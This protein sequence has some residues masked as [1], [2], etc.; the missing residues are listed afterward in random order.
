[1]SVLY[2]FLNTFLLVAAGLL[3]GIASGNTQLA[4]NENGSYSTDKLQLTEAE[5][6]WLSSHSEIR[7]G[8]MNSWPPMDFVDNEGKPEGIGAHFIAALNKRLQNKLKIFPG[9]WEE[10]YADVQEHRL[11]AIMGITP[12]ADREAYF[13]FT[14]PYATIPHA[15]FARKGAGSL[16]KLSDLV[17]KRVGLERN[18]FIVKLLQK[19]YPGIEIALYDST[20]DVLDALSKGEVDAY[21]GNRAV[22][23]YIIDTELISNIKQYGKITETSSVNAI[24]VRKD[25]P[26]LRDILQK[27]LDSMSQQEVREILRDSVKLE[28]PDYKLVLNEQEKKWLQEHPVIRTASD[29]DWAPIE[30]FDKS[31]KP[32]GISSDYFK[33]LEQLLG[34]KFER[35]KNKNWQQLVKAFKKSEVDIFSSINSTPERARY[36]DFTDSYT[37]FPIAIFGG[38]MTPYI[39]DLKSLDKLKGMKVGVVKNYVYEEIVKD[40]Y[41]DIPLVSANNVK[42]ALEMLSRGETDVYIGNILVTGYYIGQLGYSR[43]KVVGKTPFE[44]AQSIGVRKDWPVFRSILNKALKSI[45][46]ADK[47]AIYNR[48]ISV[49]YEYEFDYALLWKVLLIVFVIFIAFAF[50]NHKLKLLNNQLVV[51]RNEEERARILVEEANTQLKSMDKLKSMFIASMSHELRTPLNSIIGFSGLLLQ[52]VSGELNDKQKDSMQRINRAGNH[53]LSLISDIIDISKIEAGRVDSFPEKVLLK[54]LIDEAIESVRPL[55]DAKNMQII[56][57][58]DTFPEITADRKRLLQCLLNYLSNAIKYSER[59]VVT[60]AVVLKPETVEISV[61]DTG[62]GISEEDMPRLFEAFERMDSHLRVQ[63]GGTGLGLY[64]TKK[65]VEEILHGKVSVKSQLN[66]GSCFSLEIPL[67]VQV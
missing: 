32:Q 59:G 41:P 52:G 61:S 28:H 25:R 50:W 37:H 21:I 20:S 18:F 44:Y 51:A 48:W 9:P 66:K 62:I 54:E 2:K 15:I 27:A 30:Y 10:I 8:T 14:R 34:I 6:Q 49:R 45:P 11:D 36:I 55:A 12:R 7:I 4:N 42:Q 17:N 35:I 65:I 43:L 57:E 63:A 26:I 47:A 3:P 53:L 23:M 19:E 39:G 60:V 40:H 58:A 16:N 5:S 31:G 38:P 24:G 22:A 33:K 46:E 1:M 67:H 56:V 64:L 29:P 13:N